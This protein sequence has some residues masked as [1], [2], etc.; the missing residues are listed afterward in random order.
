MTAFRTF[1]L[2]LVLVAAPA[3]SMTAYADDPAPPPKF[4]SPFNGE[5]D[6]D[7]SEARDFA[8]LQDKM[9]KLVDAGNALARACGGPPADLAKAQT[10]YA[11]AAAAYDAAMDSYLLGWSNVSWRPETL[12][13]AKREGDFN[14]QVY[15]RERKA[16]QDELGKHAAQPRADGTCPPNEHASLP[17]TDTAGWGGAFVGI[18]VTG[19]WSDVDTFEFLHATDILTND[20]HDSGDGYGVGINGG[21]NW[22]PWDNS[23][24]VGAV[25]NVDLAHDS[26]R[27]DFGGGDYIGSVRRF[28][29]TAQGRIGTLVSPDLLLY[30][31]TGF[32][33]ADQRLQI[34]FGGP[35]TDESRTTWG[36]ALG[37]GAELMLH[38]EQFSRMSLFVDYDHIWWNNA[39]LFAPAASP[40]FDYQWKRRSD[41]VRLGVRF[42]F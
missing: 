22:Q 9:Q 27:H 40:F 26:V 12:S 31:Q 28:T 11:A 33:I 42:T 2:L 19:S 24:V 18:S 15:E 25:F 20:L 32:S 3:L 41:I 21:Y 35:E 14:H 34:E 39:S 29:G 30:G 13:A 8:A 17:P 6:A 10:D 4:H 23:V 16:V 1:A 7:S 5:K 37:G 36:Y 38:C